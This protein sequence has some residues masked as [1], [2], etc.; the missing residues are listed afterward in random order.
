MHRFAIQRLFEETA[1]W[2]GRKSQVRYAQCLWNI[3]VL[4]LF[5]YHASTPNFDGN[6]IP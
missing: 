5:E 1:L 6:R 2:M 3:T 4:K